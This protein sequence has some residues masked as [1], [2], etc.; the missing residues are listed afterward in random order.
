MAAY[1]RCFPYEKSIVINAL[2]DTIDALGLCLEGSDSARGTLVVSDARRTGRIRLVLGAAGCAEETRVDLS[3]EGADGDAWEAWNA[4]LLDELSGT[5]ER[6]CRKKA[7][8]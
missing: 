5:I 6:D 2:Y 8:S 4:V 1:S 3:S 7:D